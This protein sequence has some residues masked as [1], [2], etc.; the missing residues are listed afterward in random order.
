MP[1]RVR[2]DFWDFWK[3]FDRH[4]N[5]FTRLLRPHFDLEIVDDPDFVI[6]SCFGKRHRSF[7]GIRI[8]Y[9][10]RESPTR[11]LR[12]PISCSHS[13]TWTVP[14]IADCRSTRP[15]GP[16]RAIAAPPVARGDSRRQN[17]LLQLRFHQSSLPTVRNALVP[18][19]FE[20]QAGRLGRDVT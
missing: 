2:I 1:Q 15:R 7:P 11:F 20:V 12:Q 18:Q 10:A 16:R 4:D 8:F 19:A 9:A 17:G 3:G 5:F 6:H 14:T 13:T